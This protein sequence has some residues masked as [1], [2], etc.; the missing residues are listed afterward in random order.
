MATRRGRGDG[1]ATAMLGS[2]WANKEERAI[3]ELVRHSV[4]EEQYLYPTVRRVLP[5]G[6]ELADHEL[7][8]HAEAEEGTKALGKT[9]AG[10]PKFDKLVRQL[11][12]DIRH[13]IEG[14]KTNARSSRE[15]RRYHRPARTYPLQIARPPTR[16]WRRVR[17]LSTA[18]ATH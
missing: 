6:D 3:A 17:V 13:H 7:K 5:G 10:D 14:E 15:P 9:D 1:L 8:E 4:G 12:E 18:C 11:I 16:S 2:T